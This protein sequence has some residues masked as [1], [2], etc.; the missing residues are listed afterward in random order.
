MMSYACLNLGVRTF[1]AKIG[2]D[3]SASLALFGG[4]G[5]GEVSRS[6]IFREATLELTVASPSD[7]DG[8]GDSDGA[9]A[10]G[11]KFSDSGLATTTTTTTRASL[12]QAW[13]A[14]VKGSYDE[15]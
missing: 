12:T 1:R 6:D 10:A 15:R 11:E 9:A 2:Y 7:G 4:L 13:N 5:Y 8:D 3:N 14:L